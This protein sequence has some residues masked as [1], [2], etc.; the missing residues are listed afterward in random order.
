MGFDELYFGMGFI[1]LFLFFFGCLWWWWCG[2]LVCDA[3]RGFGSRNGRR[4]MVLVFYLLM[5]SRRTRWWITRMTRSWWEPA[6]RGS[7][8]RSGSPSTGST[9]L[10]S[11]SSSP[12]GRTPSRRRYCEKLAA[13]PLLRLAFSDNR[14]VV[15]HANIGWVLWELRCWL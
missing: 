13:T 14:F 3:M 10:A 2:S 8:R 12:R 11:P 15:H 9:R 5:C 6:A 1:Y 7:V 4:L